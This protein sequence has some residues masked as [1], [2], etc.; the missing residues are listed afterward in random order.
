VQIKV[1]A[2]YTN[3]S[4]ALDSRHSFKADL[5]TRYGRIDAGG[6]TF[7]NV[8]IRENSS[9]TGNAGNDANPSASV[10]IETSYGN[11]KLK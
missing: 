10:E 11:I 6:L 5:K 1:N 2:G 7:N 9:I 8:S 4:V 3:V